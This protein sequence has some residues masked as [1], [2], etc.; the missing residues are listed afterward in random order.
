MWEFSLNFKK[1]NCDL[2]T[3]SFNVLSKEIKRYNGI[4]TV[5]EDNNY[6]YLIMAV[7]QAFQECLKA[8]L[9]KLIIQLICNNFKSNFLDQH[10]TLPISDK[11]S[12]HAF[13]KALLN[14][15]R[16]TDKYII[17]R[18]LHLN[19]HLFVES[20]YNFKLKALK[21]KWCELIS[22]SN[23]NRDYLTSRESFIDLLKFLVDNLDIC[24]NEINVIK[25]DGVFR[26][27][28]D[29]KNFKERVESE[30]SMIASVIDL[31]PQK[32]NLYSSFSEF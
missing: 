3:L 5:C 21:D 28:S 11:V 19:N 7:Q 9:T 16:E 30:E 6:I 10:L 32:I 15:D 1:D 20:F 26:I 17:K 4:L 18:C 8:S 13:K 12:M 31:S 22:L 24:V 23:E 2:A 29:G 27:Y 25:E 14:F